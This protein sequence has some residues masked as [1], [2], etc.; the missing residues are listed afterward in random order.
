MVIFVPVLVIVSLF[1]LFSDHPLGFTISCHH[2]FVDMAVPSFGVF[3]LNLV[4]PSLVLGF[5]V[6][7]LIFGVVIVGSPV[8]GGRLFLLLLWR[9]VI[10]FPARAILI[11]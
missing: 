6:C 9:V 10:G 11:H 4:L 3:L 8:S 2:I 1:S 7:F 5:P